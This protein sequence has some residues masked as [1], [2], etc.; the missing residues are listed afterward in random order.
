MSI[1]SGSFGGGSGAPSTPEI[2]FTNYRFPGPVYTDFA[3]TT[4]VSGV[5]ADGAMVVSTANFVRYHKQGGL[6]V[7]ADTQDYLVRNATGAALEMGDLVVLDYGVV[8]GIPEASAYI[9]WTSAGASFLRR[10]LPLAAVSNYLTGSSLSPDDTA[11]ANQKVRVT[12]RG[13][14]VRVQTQ[15]V[16]IPNEELF[17]KCEDGSFTI[18]RPVGESYYSLGTVIGGPY[19]DATCNIIFEPQFFPANAFTT[20]ITAAA[21]D[22]GVKELALADR[23][24][25]AAFALELSDGTLISDGIVKW[26]AHGLPLNRI[27]YLH[28]VTAGSYTVTEPTT[29]IYQ[30]L[31]TPIDADTIRVA[32]GDW[33]YEDGAIDGGVW[34]GANVLAKR[35]VAGAWQNADLTVSTGLAEVIQY[36]GV[37]HIRSGKVRWRTA[38]TFAVGS[39]LY[40][41]GNIGAL[42]TAPLAGQIA[43]RVGQVIDARTILFDIHQVEVVPV[44]FMHRKASAQLVNVATNANIP[45]ATALTTQGSDI[46]YNNGIWTLKA[47]RCYELEAD[48]AWASDSGFMQLTWVNVATNAEL[49]VRGHF[50]TQANTVS[51][52]GVTRAFVVATADTQVALRIVRQGGV[53]AAEIGDAFAPGPQINATIK[54]VSANLAQTLQLRNLSD[55]SD[56]AYGTPKAGARLLYNATSQQWEADTVDGIVNN[57]VWFVTPWGWSFRMNGA[58]MQFEMRNDTGVTQRV[59]AERHYWLFG[60]NPNG[61]PIVRGAWPNGQ[62]ETIWGDNTLN[63]TLHG[64]MEQMRMKWSTGQDAYAAGNFQE[65][66]FTGVCGNGYNNNYITVRKLR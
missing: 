39:T 56:N 37:N 62:I 59:Y 53:N 23:P 4:P 33:R 18:T 47:N 66:E 41:V 2:Y 24:E 65:L 36:D 5:L 10:G 14:T 49:G 38:H 1:F 44:S 60:A 26:K 42:A 54:S 52:S 64:S 45:L 17:L 11:F 20:S 19:S 29:G 58:N 57:N 50:E 35:W 12:T 61:G 48:L 32:V 30:P 22:A 15:A 8:A 21:Y 7:L 3:C 40:A 46:T 25:N 34:N 51:G 55:V 31:F 13:S 43:Q 6:F 16:G 27:H 28:G 63:I 9:A